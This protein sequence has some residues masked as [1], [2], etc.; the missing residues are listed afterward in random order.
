MTWLDEVQAALSVEGFTPPG[1]QE[2]K[3]FQVFGLAKNFD[4]TWQLHVRGFR[5]QQREW[6]ESEI[7]P[8]WIYWEHLNP[9]HRTSAAAF[10]NQILNKYG[11]PFIPQWDQ[12]YTPPKTPTQLTDWRPAALG[13]AI[14][15]G[16]G[17]FFFGSQ[18]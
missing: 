6:I 9:E 18:S 3:P 7:E 1:L 11:I 16:L 17:W 10:M 12:S 13:F 5:E 2:L 14:L 15:L 8:Q 4:G